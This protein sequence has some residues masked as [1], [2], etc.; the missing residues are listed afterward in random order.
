M[1]TALKVKNITTSAHKGLNRS[2]TLQS[3]YG[4]NTKYSSKYSSEWLSLISLHLRGSFKV[5][6]A[7]NMWWSFYFL[8]SQAC[9]VN[10][11]KARCL[12]VK[13]EQ[14]QKAFSD[15]YY[16][17]KGWECRA[18]LVTDHICLRMHDS[19][20]LVCNL[21]LLLTHIHLSQINLPRQIWVGG[22]EKMFWVLLSRV[23]CVALLKNTA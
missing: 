9:V 16:R 12:W 20:V 23:K 10:K 18:A 13:D 15:Q 2:I 6:S 22:E 8:I 17:A 4:M 14:Q 21:A 11:S 19:Q 1:S 7:L 3:L 5:L